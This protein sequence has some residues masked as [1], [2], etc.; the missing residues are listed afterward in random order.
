MS[1]IGPTKKIMEFS[2]YSDSKNYFFKTLPWMRGVCM[3]NIFEI[4][5]AVSEE[6]ADKQTDRQIDGQI[7][8]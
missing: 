8:R 3:P 1:G 4:G 2:F 7:D 6:I 5:P